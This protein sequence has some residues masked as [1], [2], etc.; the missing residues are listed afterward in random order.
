MLRQASVL[1]VLSL[2][3][4][5]SSS[6]SVAPGADGGAGPIGDGPGDPPGPLGHHVTVGFAGWTCATRGDALQCWGDNSFA[7]LHRKAAGNQTNKP[8]NVDGPDGATFDQ[9]THVRAGAGATCAVRAGKAY[10]WGRSEFGALGGS[11]GPSGAPLAIDAV[12][13][14]AMGAHFGCA[15]SGAD[16][17]C[18]GRNDYGQLTS[19]YAG[20][21]PFVDA[22]LA[23]PSLAG[24]RHIALGDAHGC[25]VDQAGALRCWGRNDFRQAGPDTGDE[26]NGKPCVKKPTLVPGLTDVRLVSAGGTHTCALDGAGV[27]R[28]WGDNTSGQLGKADV[29]SMCKED[30]GGPAYPCSAEPVHVGELDGATHVAAGTQTSCAIADGNVWCWGDNQF[31]QLGRPGGQS[32]KSPPVPVTTGPNRPLEK[33]REVAASNRHACALLDGGAL[34]CWGTAQY[35]GLGVNGTFAERAVRVW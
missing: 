15:R 34:W 2:V 31:G 3:V 23:M 17:H 9:V 28:C 18:W 8:G 33:A 20:T 10:C 13:E 25:A 7:R 6:G 14:V 1:A 4:A 19:D 22:P 32:T 27:V 24:A 16:V 35:G 21:A 30:G 12:D 29:G 11:T 26:C 5:C